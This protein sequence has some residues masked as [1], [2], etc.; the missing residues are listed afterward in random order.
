MKPFRRAAL[1]AALILATGACMSPEP[2]SQ[3]VETIGRIERQA[4]ALDA[5]ISPEA[6]I[7]KLAEGFV[8]SEG[9]VWIRSGSYLLFSD[10]P[11]NRMYRWSEA[12]G[13]SVF[14]DPS[15]YAGPPTRD[16]REPGTNGLIP[17]PGDSILLADH[18]N[19]GVARLDL[20]TK[21]KTF[22]AQHY[23]GKK[24]NSPND[25]VRASDGTI[26]FTDPPYGLEG[27]ND[28][29]LKELPFNGVYKL[30][31]DGKVELVDDGMTFPNG[32]ILSPDE[33]TLYV[34]NSDPKNAI[35][36]AYT[37]DA[38]GRFAN[39]RVLKDF[40]G[41]VGEQNPGL[42]DGMT[43]DARGNLFATAPGGVH[44]LTPEGD[45]LGVIR[46]GTAIA[47]C[48]FGNDGRMLYLASDS[49]LARVP[50]LTLGLGY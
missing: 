12:D 35:L 7:E 43:I 2:N 4:P 27:L 45:S 42:P 1:A 20:A 16:F 36:V 18:G 8:W 37:R 15:G 30:S 31:S 22:L 6:K 24:F 50:T 49:M 29:R 48:A 21:Q 14:L 5:L 46:T 13:V 11:G 3:S 26:Y 33:R 17:G 32:I 41:L 44:I 40:T 23:Q 9:P 19:R 25:L 28:S 47:N 34:A 10:V 39:R 38:A